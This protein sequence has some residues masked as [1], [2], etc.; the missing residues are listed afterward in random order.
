MSLNSCPH[1]EI[2]DGTFLHRSHPGV[3]LARVRSFSPSKQEIRL[4]T[5]E[6]DCE[7]VVIGDGVDR[8]V[9][10]STF[11]SDNRQSERKSSQ[12]IQLDRKSAAELV[13]ILLKAFPDIQRP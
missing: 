3:L 6:V 13:K 2:V 10:L 7:H 12:S 11:G 9:H 1:D 4:H 5:S 8:V